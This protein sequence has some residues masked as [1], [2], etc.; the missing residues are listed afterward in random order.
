MTDSKCIEKQENGTDSAARLDVIV[1]RLDSHIA[2]MA[3][4]QRKREAGK[5]I[6]DAR[7]L[8]RAVV[9]HNAQCVCNDSVDGG[10]GYAPYYP[11]RCPNCP[12]FWKIDLGA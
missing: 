1:M 9:E 10:C 7:E 11:R 6:I 12:E 8:A 4:H 3:P 5:L 2:Q